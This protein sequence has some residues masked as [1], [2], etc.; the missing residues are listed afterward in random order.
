M[1]NRSTTHRQLPEAVEIELIRSV[2]HA[3]VPA[4]VM[5]LCFLAAGVEIYLRTRDPILLALLIGGMVAS[6]AR[7]SLVFSSREIHSKSLTITRAR[8]LEFRFTLAYLAFALFLGMFGARALLTDSA[9]IHMLVMCLLFSYCAG[10][11]VGMGLRLRIA[12]PAMFVTLGP[13]VCV[14]MIN[15]TTIYRITGA[16]VAAILLSGSQSLRNKHQRSVQDIG[17]RLTFSNLARKDPLT[18]LPNRI[19]MREWYDER[20]V[21][22]NG[23]RLMAVHY[24][25]LNGFKP[26]NDSHGHPVGDALLTAVGKRI[27]RTIRDSDIVARLGGDEFAVIQY[28]IKNADEAAQLA[29][30]ITDA[31]CSPFRIGHL[32]INISAGLGYVV[33]K[34]QEEDLD[35]L[36]NLADQALYTSKRQGEISQYDAVETITK[37]VA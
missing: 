9:E 11:A 28:D 8:L 32:T 14:A 24:L 5:T 15:E 25:D 21:V 33:A 12:L 20:M 26:V 13:A 10:V 17:L 1:K 35:H 7:L 6:V 19:A 3:F 22:N 36:L 27:A 37:R 4:L 34:G 29:A 31:I 16:L 23:A 30:R 18:A 2:F